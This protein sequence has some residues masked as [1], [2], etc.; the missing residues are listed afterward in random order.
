MIKDKRS[1]HTGCG[2]QGSDKSSSLRRKDLLRQ[3]RNWREATI[4]REGFILKGLTVVRHQQHRY[5]S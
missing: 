3:D 1:V 5:T 4:L 2:R